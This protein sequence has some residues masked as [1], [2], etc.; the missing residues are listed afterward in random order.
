LLWLNVLTD[1][2]YDRA[3]AKTPRAQNI[4]VGNYHDFAKIVSTTT[5]P[6]NP[7]HSNLVIHTD[8]T[9]AAV[10]FDF[11]F[12]TDGIATNTG[13]ET[14]QLVKTVDGWRIAA[15]CYSSNRPVQQ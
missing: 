9:I 6:L 5:K 13:S 14:W 12:K 7:E 4:R 1:S 3:K 11:V 10:Y 2:T 8:G 15:I